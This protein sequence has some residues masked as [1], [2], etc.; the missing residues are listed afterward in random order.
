[1]CKGLCDSVFIRADLQTTFIECGI[2]TV[3][4]VSRDRVFS[5][6]FSFLHLL[7]LSLLSLPSQEWLNPLPDHSLPHLKI[8]EAILDILKSVCTAMWDDSE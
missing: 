2:L 5:L 1:M 3:L 8:R 7:P 6:A 4:A